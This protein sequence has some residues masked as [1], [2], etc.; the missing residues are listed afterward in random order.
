[1]V[2]IE[3]MDWEVYW[4]DASLIVIVAHAWPVYASVFMVDLCLYVK[5]TC[6]TAF[7]HRLDILLS[8]RVRTYEDRLVSDPLEREVA[9]EVCVTLLDVP[10]DKENLVAVAPLEHRLSKATALARLLLKSLVL[11]CWKDAQLTGRFTLPDGDIICMIQNRVFV[12]KA[13][14]ELFL[15]VANV[16]EFPRLHSFTCQPDAWFS[17]AQ[18][19]WP[20]ALVPVTKGFSSTIDPH[21]LSPWKWMI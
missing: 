19:H 3:V 6:D 8:L 5:D 9:H 20:S 13:L 11:L 17:D 1:M 7:S 15:A 16:F 10:I 4:F 12:N 18:E 2:L 21:A 14:G